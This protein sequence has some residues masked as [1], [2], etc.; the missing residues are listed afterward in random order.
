M[1]TPK[2]IKYYEAIGRRKEA[3]ALVR[4]YISGKEKVATV[5]DKKIKAGETLLNGMPIEKYFSMSSEKALYSKPYELTNNVGR[6]AASIL[7]TGGGHSGQLEAVILGISRAL[8][9]VD[10]ETYKPLLSAEGLL[11]RDPRAKER[12]K[13]GT[14]GKARRQKQSPKR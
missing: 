9:L 13:V 12:R 2:T 4:L 6:F 11:T 7:V 8:I 14:G 5:G 1:K 3:V 10:L